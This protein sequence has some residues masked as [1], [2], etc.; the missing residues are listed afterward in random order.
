M[1]GS[2]RFGAQ[3]AMILGKKL[4][5]AGTGTTAVAI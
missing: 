3:G 4:P 1:E 2:Y 5:F